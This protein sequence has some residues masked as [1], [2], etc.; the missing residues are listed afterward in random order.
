[1]TQK[2]ARRRIMLS[3]A[4]E[5]KESA[6]RADPAKMKRRE[7]ARRGRINAR[8]DD[9]HRQIDMLEYSSQYDWRN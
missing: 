2:Q 6:F 4:R 5:A 3:N 9:S 8:P 7:A 1:M